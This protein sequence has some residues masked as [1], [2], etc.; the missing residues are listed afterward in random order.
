MSINRREYFGDK[1]DRLSPAAKAT[2]EGFVFHFDRHGRSGWYWKQVVDVEATMQAG[3]PVRRGPFKSRRYALAD[4]CN[5]VQRRAEL[6]STR[7]DPSQQVDHVVP[8]KL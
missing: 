1:V 5:E 2:P 8:T 7:S 4:V 6:V 3:H